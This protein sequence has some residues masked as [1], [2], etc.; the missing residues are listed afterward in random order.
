[1]TVEPTATETLLPRTPPVEKTPAPVTPSP[2]P[3]LEPTPGRLPASGGV[4]TP[5]ARWAFTLGGAALLLGLIAVAYLVRLVR[6]FS[7]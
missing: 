2:T 3:S 1:M 4:R 5:V 7:S 6:G